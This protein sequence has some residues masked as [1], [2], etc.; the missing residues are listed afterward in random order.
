VLELAPQAT[1]RLSGE[2]LAGARAILDL[3]DCPLPGIYPPTAE[4]SRALR[5]PLRVVQARGSGFVQ[6][7]H[8]FDPG[9]YGEYGFAGDTSVAYRR[10]I[11]W[12]AD[13]V[14]DG[15]DASTPVLEVGC[16]DGLLLDLLARRGFGDRLGID[17]GRAATGSDRDDILG[18]YFPD[19]LDAAVPGRRYGLIVAR[20]VLE[21]IET[22][23]PFAEALAARLD[24]DGELWI[25]VPDLDSTVERELWSNLYQLHCNYFDAATLDALAARAGLRCVGGEIV[26]VFGGSLL[27]RY[28]HGDPGAIPAPPERDGLPARI[29]AFRG[30]LDALARALPDGAAGYGAAERTA[31]TLGAAPALERRLDALYDGNRLLHGRHLA[32]TALRIGAPEE[33][34]AARP[35]A[36]VVFAVSHAAEILA[37]F[38]DRLPGDT[39]VA[40]A[41]VDTAPAPLSATAAPT[42][43][44]S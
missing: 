5:S 34:E 15:F 22:P 7:A 24:P 32:G 33:L 2:P 18:G 27:R 4:E 11:E 19:D 44:R 31:M 30:R 42:I 39:L 36:V 21:H 29:D 35:A 16:G 26:E 13:A 14:A 23:V 41:G 1:C 17:P 20:H 6:L 9:I 10:H 8:R 43:P 12:F 40:I 25:E 38:R 3:P 37:G 28:R